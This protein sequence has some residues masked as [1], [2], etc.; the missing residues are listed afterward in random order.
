VRALYGLKSAGAAFQ[1][2]LATIIHH[3]LN[4]IPCE[5]D[6]DVWMRVATKDNDFGYYEYALCYVDD[7][8]F[9]S[10]KEDS[11]IKELEQHFELKVAPD[12]AEQEQ[13]YLGA[14]IEKYEFSDGS[15]AWY[16]SAEEYLKKAIPTVEE[17]WDEK[18]YKK[19][20]SPLPKGYHLEVDMT[21]LLGEDDAQLYAS[22]IGILQ[23]AQEFGRIDLAQAVGLM[24][25]FHA[26]PRKGHMKAILHIFGYMKEH[27]RSKIVFYPGY[28]DWSFVDWLEAD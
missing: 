7:M 15:T 25:R 27:L 26:A 10:A 28:H 14:M 19:V 3:G 23:W 22:Y 24:L 5:A 11:V 21:P 4:F 18:L 9:I 17:V 6:P 8:M 20:L 1:S 12:P 2:H 16:M 13:C